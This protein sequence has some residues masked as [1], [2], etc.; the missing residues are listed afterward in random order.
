MRLVQDGKPRRVTGVELHAMTA[1]KLAELA[2]QREAQQEDIVR[3]RELRR[4][5]QRAETRYLR[6]I[7]LLLLLLVVMGLTGGEYEIGFLAAF[8]LMTWAVWL[9][10]GYAKEPWEKAVAAMKA[11]ALQREGNRAR[12]GR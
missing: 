6:C 2:A 4:A 1:E 3:S 5:K 8:A 7:A 12:D 9:S 11:K 10:L